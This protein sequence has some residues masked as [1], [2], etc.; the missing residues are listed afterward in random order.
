MF[1]VAPQAKTLRRVHKVLPAPR[2][3][4]QPISHLPR[5]I[6]S[7]IMSDKYAR[8]ETVMVGSEAAREKDMVGSGYHVQG[9]RKA[10]IAEAAVIY[11]DIETAENYGYVARG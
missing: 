11:G 7:A 2:D 6:T 9:D 1:R 8:E 5:S 3:V 10:S 4:L